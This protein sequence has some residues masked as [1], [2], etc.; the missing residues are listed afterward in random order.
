[1]AP[2]L[3]LPPDFAIGFDGDE[4][5]LRDVDEDKFCRLNYEAVLH[6]LCNAERCNTMP[7]DSLILV[8]IAACLQ[9]IGRE[10]AQELFTWS[11]DS[12]SE[13]LN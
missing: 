7:R 1:M 9:C 5:I 13:T 4:V 2:D 8:A 11:L 12:V 10:R 6:D 3:N